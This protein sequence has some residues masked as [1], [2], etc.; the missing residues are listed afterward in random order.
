MRSSTARVGKLQH[1][2]HRCI[3]AS[4]RTLIG[5]TI[6]SLVAVPLF[7]PNRTQSALAATAPL[8]TFTN[9]GTL[10]GFAGSAGVDVNAHGDVVGW[11][12]SNDIMASP[13][14]FLYHNG[15]MVELGTLPGGTASKGFGINDAGE[16]VG[17]SD[18]GNSGHTHAVLFQNSKVTDLGTLP[19][20]TFSR[21]TDINDAGDAVGTSQIAGGGAHA[22][23]FHHGKVIDLGTLP[24]TTYSEGD[25]INASGEVVGLSGNHVF[26]YRHGMM[27][28]LGA[29]PVNTLRPVDIND[30]GDVVGTSS[31]TGHAFLYHAGVMTDLGSI[32]PGRSSGAR[33]INNA[34]DVVGEAEGPFGAV[35]PFLYHHGVLIDLTDAI[36]SGTASLQTASAINDGHEIVGLAGSVAYLL[37]PAPSHLDGSLAPSFRPVEGHRSS[38]AI[39]RFTDTNIFVSASQLTATVTWGDGSISSGALSGS[40]GHFTVLGSHTY[41][42][43]GSYPVSVTVQ[44]QTPGKGKGTASGTV[45]VAE[46]DALSPAAARL[47][48]ATAGHAFTGRVASF[49]DATMANTAR[50]F[51]ATI[52]WADGTSSRGI[53]SGSAG[54]F[55]VSGSHTYILPGQYAVQT[56]IADDAPG[57]AGAMATTS[58]R[59]LVPASTKGSTA[60]ASGTTDCTKVGTA[61]SVS[62]S[63]TL[64]GTFFLRDERAGGAPCGPDRASVVT[65]QSV[66]ADALVCTSSTSATLYGRAQQSIAPSATTSTVAFRADLSITGRSS[67]FNGTVRVQTGA[68]YTSEVVPAAVRISGC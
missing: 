43:E 56:R 32:W 26:L 61:T 8:Y 14:S 60:A 35:H 27:T 29:T 49:S 23:V 68:G 65:L 38:G 39:A 37:R 48:S 50:D 41:G 34:G 57:T 24:G 5:L 46:G 64:H 53:V 12:V 54:R 58:F 59:V 19:G 21:A 9:L 10:P 6:L 18:G 4:R 52:D 40:D 15:R 28:D 66:A 31:A 42:D 16:V 2:Q 63:G 17:E 36:P 30:A 45:A 11:L 67:P 25:A 13:R 47:P 51:G 22:V 7:A 3:G 20:G 33:G 44:E 1:V 62:A 55:V